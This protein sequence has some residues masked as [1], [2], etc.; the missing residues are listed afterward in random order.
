MVPSEGDEPSPGASGFLRDLAQRS[1]EN[2]TACASARDGETRNV[3]VGGVL[4]P[5]EPR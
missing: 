2:F 5:Q 1:L 3:I 4:N